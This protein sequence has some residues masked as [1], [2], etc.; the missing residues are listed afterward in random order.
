M[1]LEWILFTVIASVITETQAAFVVH[2]THCTLFALSASDA[3]M[4]SKQCNS[5][6][7]SLHEVQSLCA[8][9]HMITNSHFLPV[10]IMGWM[11]FSGFISTLKWNTGCMQR[12]QWCPACFSLWILSHLLVGV[13]RFHSWTQMS[14]LSFFPC[15]HEVVWFKV[16]S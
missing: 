12:K 6:F 1:F 3:W 7:C 14:V 2:Y 8:A 4:S 11:W 10:T 16:T 13:L 15:A 9:L 5:V